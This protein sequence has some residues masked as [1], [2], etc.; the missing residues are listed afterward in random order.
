VIFGKISIWIF[1][2]NSLDVDRKC[3]RKEKFILILENPI[4]AKGE[5]QQQQ[6]APGDSPVSS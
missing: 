6:P 1:I 5:Q 4:E 2:G 3:K